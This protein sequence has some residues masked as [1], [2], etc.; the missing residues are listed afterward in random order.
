MNVAVLV[1]EHCTPLASI[2]SLEILAKAVELYTGPEGPGIFSLSLVSLRPGPVMTSAGYPV[3]THA[4]I[5]QVGTPDLVIV[6]PLDRDILAQ[7]RDNRAVVEWVAAAYASGASIVSLCTGAFIL[8]EAGLLDGR[9]AT[10]H[11]AA[12]GLFRARYP[13]V[14]L[15][16]E[17]IIVDG[18]RVC[19]GGGV[20]SFLTVMVY[21][22]EK[23]CGADTARLI[24]HLFL[25]DRNKDPQTAYAIFAGQKDHGDD[26]VLK[27]QA[28]VEQGSGPLQVQALAD[29]VG[30]SRRH[31]VRRFKQATGNTPQEYIQRV[32]VEAAK[33]ELEQSDVPFSRIAEGVGYEDLGSFRK[34][35]TRFT[36]VSPSEY[37]RRY[38]RP[39]MAASAPLRPSP[40]STQRAAAAAASTRPR[41]R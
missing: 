17:R 24:S 6:P 32:R 23:Y 12:E 3:Y 38:R 36:G 39:M 31:F 20:T 41:G 27:A 22:V 18:G 25:I 19:T 2:G 13:G 8:A 28:L 1:L 7:L 26:Q 14:D 34:L 4:T 30:I 35:F 9:P 29:A 16:P 10:T 15:R 37:R 21:L 11:W 5:D 40:R 33:R